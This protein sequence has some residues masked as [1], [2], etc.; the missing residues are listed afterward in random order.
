MPSYKERKRLESLVFQEAEGRS[1]W[2]DGLDHAVKR[3]VAYVLDTVADK[4]AGPLGVTWTSRVWEIASNRFN[5]ETGKPPEDYDY[6]AL[7]RESDDD[8]VLS[9]IEI[10][11][12]MIPTSELFEAMRSEI[13]RIFDDHRVNFQLAPNE[14]IFPRD[15]QEIHARVTLPT[16]Q[17]LHG[18][19]EFVKAETAY[20]DA[21]REIADG[22]PANAI[23]DAGVA[24][25]ETLKALGVEG[26][27][28]GDQLKAAKK[29]S[30][31]FASR[32]QPLLEGISKFGSWASAERNINGDA[33]NVTAAVVD[34]AWLMVHVVGALILRL[35]GKPRE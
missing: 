18:R 9:F 6:E 23:T 25:Q 2:T 7:A 32:D 20:M 26:N 17:L 22:R 28:L 34:D 16:I 24:L 10:L 8:I 33:H 12:D 11:A 27:A 1:F 35:A 30:G 31:L 15:S 3:K 21:L 5:F 14:Q 19:P 4:I 13:N 29:M